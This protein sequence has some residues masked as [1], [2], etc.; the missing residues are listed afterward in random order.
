MPALARRLPLPATVALVLASACGGA[1]TPPAV[2][3]DVSSAVGRKVQVEKAWR[4]GHLADDGVVTALKV[5]G[6]YEV[7]DARIVTAGPAS[8][9]SYAVR[10]VSEGG[11]WVRLGPDGEEALEEAFSTR[12]GRTVTTSGLAL[13][14]LLPRR[15]DV[16]IPRT[17]PAR[18]AMVSDDRSL[19]FTGEGFLVRCAGGDDATRATVATPACQGCDRMSAEPSEYV[20]CKGK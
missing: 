8:I 20:T 10:I 7:A 5:Q 18:A 9:P 17:E 3:E 4:W 6:I 12:T 13:V 15:G 2:P 1:S 11:Q 19:A 16:S 14:D